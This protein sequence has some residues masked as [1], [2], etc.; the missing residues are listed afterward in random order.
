[1]RKYA[2]AVCFLAL[3]PV[4]RGQM[5][6]PAR[7]IRIHNLKLEGVSEVPKTDLAAIDE[8]LKRECCGHAETQE[9]RKQIVY[10]FQ[11]RGYV[12]VRI[13]RMEVIPMDTHTAPPAV[14]I[15]ADISPGQ[16]FR[17]KSIQFRGNEA[18]P[19]NPLRQQFLISDGELFNVEKIRQG[20]NNLRQIYATQGYINYA[21]VPNT[22]ADERSGTVT[23]TIDSDEGVQFR[24]GGLLLDGEEP[25]EGDGAKLLSAWKP[26]EGKAYDA[27]KIE[28]W[29]QLAATMLPPGSKLEQ[30]LGLMQDPKANTVTG[31]LNFPAA[32]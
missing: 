7:A 32:N 23:L 30:S 13:D 20:L 26:M 3:L 9:M 18:I 29:W 12:K 24:L 14:N 17:L 5:G 21:P 31:V 22:E 4:L 8:E 15:S 28:E 16:R 6:S 11:E 27:R 10:A 1:M 2:V 25:H 19:S